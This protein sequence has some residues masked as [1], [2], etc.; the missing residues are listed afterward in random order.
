MSQSKKRNNE[1]TGD[2]PPPKK[3]K[4]NEMQV[5]HIQGVFVYYKCVIAL[6]GEGVSEQK[7][8]ADALVYA[9]KVGNQHQFQLY[10]SQRQTYKL[11]KSSHV[12]QLQQGTAP[13]YMPVTNDQGQVVKY[14]VDWPEQA[15]YTTTCTHESHST[16]PCTIRLYYDN[17]TTDTG[18]EYIIVALVFGRYSCINNNF[19]WTENI[20]LTP[21][22]AVYACAETEFGN[23]DTILVQINSRF[24][25]HT[26]QKHFQLPK[27]FD[28]KISRWMVEYEHINR[29]AVSCFYTRRKRIT[30]FI[31]DIER[32]DM[33][34]CS[35][36]HKTQHS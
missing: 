34:Q 10:R 30:Y 13:D 4:Q 11:W 36:L 3:P 1:S 21:G 35:L 17:D 15:F 24:N 18:N 12:Y 20:N 26:L 25:Q 32:D 2:P 28:K 27:Q 23:P 22:Q 16:N 9:T 5:Q 14:I 7:K 31:S 29:Y 19:T 6:Q 33:F 8:Q